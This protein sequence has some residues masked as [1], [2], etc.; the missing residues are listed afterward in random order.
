MQEITREDILLIRSKIKSATVKGAAGYA[1]AKMYDY[2]TKELCK[3]VVRRYRKIEPSMETLYQEFY[4][5]FYL[6]TQPLIFE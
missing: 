2:Q 1:M 4:N 3:Y 6:T 5:E